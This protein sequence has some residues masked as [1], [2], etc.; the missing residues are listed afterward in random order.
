[1]ARPTATHTFVLL[2]V[3]EAAWK[4][5]HDL[6]KAAEYDHAFIESNGRIVIDMHGIA[7]EKA[8]K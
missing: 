5:I 8:E 7:L 3:S 1:M 4:E 6:L 2:E